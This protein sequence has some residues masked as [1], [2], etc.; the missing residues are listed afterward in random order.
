MRKCFQKSQFTVKMIDL[1]YCVW[2]YKYFFSIA[3]IIYFKYPWPGYIQVREKKIP[4]LCL[5]STLE[6]YIFFPDH[7]LEKHSIF[8]DHEQYRNRTKQ[9]NCILNTYFLSYFLKRIIFL[10]HSI[11]NTSHD[12]WK[13]IW[14]KKNK[15]HLLC[16]SRSKRSLGEVW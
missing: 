13:V 4:W 5:T 15:P 9:P 16:K 7:L 2:N 10:P 11:A 6:M 8:P 14:M 12:L 1:G 3:S